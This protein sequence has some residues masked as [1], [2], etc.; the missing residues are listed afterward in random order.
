MIGVNIH[1]SKYKRNSFIVSICPTTVSQDKIDLGGYNLK[2]WSLIIM[3]ASLGITFVVFAVGFAVAIV[4]NPQI[5]ITGNIDLSQF[6][7]VIIGISMVAVVL[8][9]QQLTAKAQ[10]S[11]VAS[12]DKVWLESEE[13]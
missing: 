8:V 10:A 13:K 6:T 1:T 12:T 3:W 9:G 7:G 2:E 5:V 4:N 11:A